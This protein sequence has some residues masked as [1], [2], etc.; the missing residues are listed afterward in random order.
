LEVS[1]IDL[2]RLLAVVLLCKENIYHLA[3][4]AQPSLRTWTTSIANTQ[5]STQ[6]QW[7]HL[8]D[9]V[10]ASLHSLV[11]RQQAQAVQRQTLQWIWIQKVYHRCTKA[12]WIKLWA[13]SFLKL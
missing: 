2:L 5:A 3:E 1:E 7:H 11:L 9:F 6:A 10:P 12:P 8:E 13:S 4:Q